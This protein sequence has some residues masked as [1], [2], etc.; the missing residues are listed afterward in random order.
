MGDFEAILE[1]G[2]VAAVELAA[3]ALA[4]GGRKPANCPNCTSPL[5]GPYCA[6]C[7][8]PTETHRR[9]VKHLIVDFVSD[10]VTWDS[11]ILRTLRA[12]LFQPGELALAFRE[13]RTQRY[14]PAVRLY[15]FVS[16]LFFLLL[17]ATNIAIM[18]FDVHISSSKIMQDKDH[19][20]ILVS[21]GDVTHMV[22]F[23]GDA[24]G[25]V[26]LASAP[27]V[28][29]PDMKADGHL[30]SN[31]DNSVRFF[32]RIGTGTKLSAKDRA[33]LDKI[34]AEELADA[35]KDTSGGWAV[36]ASAL[37]MQ[38]LATNP[39][40]LNGPLTTWIP[41]V[42]FL[43]LPLFALM[44]SLFYI[45]QRK[46]FYFVDH[47]VFSL[48]LHSFA[49]VLVIL[50]AIVAQFAP[51]EWL[52][53]VV[54]LAFAVYLLLALKRAYQQGWTITVIKFLAISFFYTS[55]LLA[56]ALAAAIVASI[57]V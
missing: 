15:L 30:T 55:F 4:K 18:Q 28:N 12:L 22:G 54:A 33:L 24:N 14:V 43:L 35:K 46:S 53:T 27:S 42:L 8:Q 41:R 19:N 32:Q 56:P 47:L 7:G 21:N 40:A 3:S 16:L 17:S 37:T 50:A 13:G 9:S 11:R 38:K 10:L 5:V 45:R 6:V 23:K 44:L 52:G 26:H 39:A 25:N 49:F 48:T 51:G 57:F 34:N 2:S 36:K 20:V 29:I 31:I 1:T